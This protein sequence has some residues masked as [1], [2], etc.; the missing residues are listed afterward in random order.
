MCVFVRTVFKGKITLDEERFVHQ[1][2]RYYFSLFLSLYFSVI[3]A[4]AIFQLLFRYFRYFPYFF[5]YIRYFFRY[6]RYF[7]TIYVA[8]YFVVV[9]FRFSCTFTLQLVAGCSLAVCFCNQFLQFAISLP[10]RSNG[11]C[12]AISILFSRG[13]HLGYSN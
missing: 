11:D 6:F 1:R 5:R 3:F 2:F 8:V 4:I 10:L 7:S 12:D 9:T 13:Y